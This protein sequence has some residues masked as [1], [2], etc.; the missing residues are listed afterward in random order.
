MV[1]ACNDPEIDMNAMNKVTEF[2]EPFNAELILVHVDNGDG[3]FLSPELVNHWKEK[4]PKSHVHVDTISDDSI[5]DGLN[6][7]CID[8]HID[9]LILATSKRGFFNDLF[10]KSVTRRMAINTKIP[11]LICHNN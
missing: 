2:I 10:H 11:L 8:N 1:Y 9:C 3:N 6:N 7:Y 5:I 4:Y